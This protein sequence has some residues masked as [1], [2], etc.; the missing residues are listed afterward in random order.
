MKTNSRSYEETTNHDRDG[1]NEMGEPSRDRSFH[2]LEQDNA[3]LRIIITELLMENQQLRW[4]LLGG[5]ETE[6]A[7]LYS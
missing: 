2:L 4:E 3:R 6:L 5:K 1:R 7:K